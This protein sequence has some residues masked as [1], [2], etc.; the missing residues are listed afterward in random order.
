M[1]S[2]F[3]AVVEVVSFQERLGR[4]APAQLGAREWDRVPVQPAGPPLVI[5]GDERQGVALVQQID[6]GAG[7]LAT[8]GEGRGDLVD[9]GS[10]A[11]LRRGEL[12]ER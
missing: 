2:L 1:R 4:V 9:V 8:E 6:R 12:I 10:G 11:W 7:W 5:V 3:R